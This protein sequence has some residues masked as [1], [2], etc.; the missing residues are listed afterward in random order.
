MRHLVCGFDDFCLCLRTLCSSVAH[1][2][3]QDSFAGGDTAFLAF[4]DASLEVALNQLLGV[5]D[6]LIAHTFKKQSDHVERDLAVK[7]WR[8]FD[9]I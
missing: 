7:S 4:F 9:T 6:Q 8:L 3:I 1:K 5:A 2:T